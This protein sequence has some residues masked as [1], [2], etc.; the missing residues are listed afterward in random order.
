MT[1]EKQ[2]HR[3]SGRLGGLATL[4]K[5]GLPYY[6]EIGKKGGAR[7]RELIEAGKAAA[8]L[9]EEIKDLY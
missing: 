1:E 9:A 8:K 6:R 4:Q 7:V 3:E 5:Y 2:G